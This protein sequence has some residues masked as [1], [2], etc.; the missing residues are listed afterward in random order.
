MSKYVY[1]CLMKAADIKKLIENVPLSISDIEMRIGMPKTTLQKALK[2][3]RDLPKKWQLKLNFFIEKK[4]YLT[5][6]EQ[7]AE[8]NKPEN[9]ERILQ[10][11]NRVATSEHR[12]NPI[13]LDEATTKHHLWK[14]DDPKE[15]SMAFFMKYG[16]NNY[17]ELQN[18]L[19]ENKP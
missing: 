18:K 9:K 5:L 11:R 7:I 13:T 3:G 16:C 14:E 12:Q 1:F 19:N 6:N 17:E 8:N 15:N 2:G 4:Q 10:T